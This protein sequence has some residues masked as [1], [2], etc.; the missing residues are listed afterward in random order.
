VAARARRVHSAPA[1]G[2]RRS[3]V[4]GPPAD[5]RLLARW[6]EVGLSSLMS[7]SAW[8]PSL[9]VAV[10]VRPA[11]C[12][13][14]GQRR[15]TASRARGDG[16]A[17]PGG[18]LLLTGSRGRTP[19]GSPLQ[20]YGRV[21][22]ERRH[23]RLTHSEGRRGR[24]IHQCGCAPTRHRSATHWRVERRAAGCR[25]SP[26]LLSMHTG[27]RRR[28]STGMGSGRPHSGQW[29][30]YP[31]SPRA[32][33]LLAMCNDQLAPALTEPGGLPTRPLSRRGSTTRASSQPACGPWSA[34]DAPSMRGGNRAAAARPR[35]DGRR[36]SRHPDR[37]GGRRARCGLR[38][39]E[40]AFSANGI[41]ALTIA[42]VAING[43]NRLASPCARRS[44][45]TSHLAPRHRTRPRRPDVERVRRPRADTP[46]E[47]H[48]R[49]QRCP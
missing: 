19:L 39:V 43:W 37:A 2:A 48:N 22:L 38:R 27:S 45:N 13:P 3:H 25:P 33:A 24:S 44:A 15:K 4:T 20:R 40:L 28:G 35:E 1:A 9:P 46:P 10:H 18:S 32:G 47:H 26:R 36:R 17:E 29:S 14:A 30:P 6:A 34:C 5:G 7:A 12:V 42:I 41:V 31:R 16:R 21:A 11:A 49:S 23:R 8:C